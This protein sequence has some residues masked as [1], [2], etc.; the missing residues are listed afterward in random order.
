[1]LEH[2]LS[3]KPD[4]IYQE[5]EA[6]NDSD[7]I[8]K[9]FDLNVDEFPVIN[10]DIPFNSFFKDQFKPNLQLCFGELLKSEEHRPALIA[11]QRE[12]YQT[13]NNKIDQVANQNKKVLK[14][15]EE[16]GKQ[17]KQKQYVKSIDQLSRIKGKISKGS[18]IN[19]LPEFLEIINSQNQTI[20]QNTKLLIDTTGRLEED[21]TE[22]K[23]ISKGFL[24]VLNKNWISKNKVLTASIITFL[25]IVIAGFS[26]NYIT[27]PFNTVINIDISPELE[28]HPNYPPLLF[29]AP[30]DKFAKNGLSRNFR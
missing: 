3:E 17:D 7:K 21:V 18:G 10:P 14:Q 16:S 6:S 11:Y 19:I 26:Y 23:G 1:M 29:I 5:I 30:V 4:S 13:I 24:K 12:V 9:I 25:L 27:A 8:F 22:L 20:E 15:L 28:I 2:V